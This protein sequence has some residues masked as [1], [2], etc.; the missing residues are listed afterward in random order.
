MRRQSLPSRSRRKL[1]GDIV[2]QPWFVDVKTARSIRHFLPPAFF[3]K[4][5][6]Y[7]EDWGCLVCKRRNVP[8]ASNGMCRTCV[9]RTQ[10]RLF[11]CLQ[12]RHLPNDVP[13]P[14]PDNLDRVN[15]ARKLLSDLISVRGK[16]R[17]KLRK[18]QRH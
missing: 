4:M 11:F 5:R 13:T 17:M 7:F 12:T 2:L 15:S 18:F 9:Q 1:T 3:H 10:K 14:R 8:Y 6:Y 16:P